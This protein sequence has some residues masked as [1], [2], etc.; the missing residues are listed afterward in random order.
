M[1]Q[2]KFALQTIDHD[3]SDQQIQKPKLPL[4]HKSTTSAEAPSSFYTPQSNI[5]VRMLKNQGQAVR[6]Q[7]PNI[8]NKQTPYGVEKIGSPTFTGTTT[9]HSQMSV[10][11]PQHNFSNSYCGF[12]FRI[13]ENVAKSNTRQTQSNL[14]QRQQPSSPILGSPKLDHTK[15][16]PIMYTPVIKN[17]K[18]IK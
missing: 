2:E 6:F 4:Q 3:L 14:K 8:S 15:V 17:A 12:S 1:S 5:K 16:W 18:L 7:S 13:R 10:G 9:K 11:S